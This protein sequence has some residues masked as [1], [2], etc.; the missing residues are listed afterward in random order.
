MTQSRFPLPHGLI[1]AE[2][3]V[4]GPLENY[5]IEKS[6][7]QPTRSPMPSVRSSQSGQVSGA[8]CHVSGQGM[9]DCRENGCA[10]GALECGGLTPPSLSPVPYQPACKTRPFRQPEA[11]HGPWKEGG[12]KPP[13]PKSLRA[14]S[15]TVV[16][17]SIMNSPLGMRA[18]RV[19]R[20][21]VK[22]SGFYLRA[23][24]TFVF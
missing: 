2:Q 13:H 19:L 4:L 14:F 22:V 8:G 6:Q 12:V 7:S 16:T 5:Q 20:Q 11:R 9:S 3:I 10:E 15:S 24:N 1:C 23:L 18:L 21:P 17:R